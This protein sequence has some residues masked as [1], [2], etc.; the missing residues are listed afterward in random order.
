MAREEFVLK[1][2]IDFA[3][4]SDL[5]LGGSIAAKFRQLE[6]RVF[7]KE[8]AAKVSM[9]VGKQ[10]LG[11][12]A[13]PFYSGVKVAASAKRFQKN[14]TKLNIPLELKFKEAIA[15]KFSKAG[16][17]YGYGT[18]A[19][20]AE[21]TIKNRTEG[22]SKVPLLRTEKLRAASK[23]GYHLEKFSI[24]DKEKGSGMEPGTSIVKLN[25]SPSAKFVFKDIN[26]PPKYWKGSL[27]TFG[28]LI[29][30]HL[31]GSERGGHKR[32]IPL[33]K[34]QFLQFVWGPFLREDFNSLVRK[35]RSESKRPDSKINTAALAYIEK[36]FGKVISKHPEVRKV[37]PKINIRLGDWKDTLKVF[38]PM[39]YKQ[40]N[41]VWKF[42]LDALG[43]Y[44]RQGYAIE[45][46]D[47][48]GGEED[49][50]EEQ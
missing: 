2:D 36:N 8:T 40:I 7:A 41:E 14:I 16:G 24:F 22:Q 49:T 4:K 35:E 12:L 37:L 46:N 25:I 23:L 30:S 6:S 39:S 32:P 44:V 33:T 31:R 26:L 47:E 38:E 5:F 21:S 50:G 28:N 29:I 17:G 27:S 15:R 9:Y 19:A 45:Y 34:R 42:F 13:I 20:L 48:I 1:G 43:S 3:V 10:L 18:W 11:P